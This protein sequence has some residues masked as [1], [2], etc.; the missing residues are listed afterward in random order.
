MDSDT[1]SKLLHNNHI[2]SALFIG[3]YLNSNLNYDVLLSSTN[4]FCIVNTLSSP[5]GMGH[6]ICLY[7]KNS[8][9]I[10]IDSFANQPE[11]YGGDISDFFLSYPHRRMQL[12]NRAVQAPNSMICGGYVCVL[13]Y[14]L[15]SN[16][17]ILHIKNIFKRA[18]NCNDSLISR[19]MCR[20]FSMDLDALL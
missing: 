14:M 13:A 10:F 3:C 7:I 8:K 6:W 15:A 11:L 5:K 9:L 2:T 19:I 12:F 20:I 4:A 17:A 18:K 16:R 1:I